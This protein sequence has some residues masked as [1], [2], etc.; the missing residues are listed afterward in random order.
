M[1]PLFKSKLFADRACIHFKVKTHYLDLFKVELMKRRLSMQETF[2]ELVRLVVEGDPG[3]LKIIDRIVYN[4][5]KEKMDKLLDAKIEPTK[6]QERALKKRPDPVPVD[7][8]NQ[9]RL[10]DLLERANPL[11]QDEEKP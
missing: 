9:E 7:A 6:V 10:F 5:N 8:H 4:K 1:P 3:A 11:H 2:D